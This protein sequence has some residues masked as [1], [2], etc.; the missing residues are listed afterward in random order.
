MMAAMP[1]AEVVGA[2]G[3]VVVTGETA[4]ATPVVGTPAVTSAAAKEVAPLPVEMVV[5][6][7]LTVEA[8][9][10]EVVVT[11][12][13]TLMLLVCSRWRPLPE[14]AVTPVMVMALAATLSCVARVFTN[15]VCTAPV[16]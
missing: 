11:V 12:N 9:V 4:R 14:A 1:A 2:A 16:N 13:A 7:L 10:E 15:A 6:W 3:A 8:T 5:I